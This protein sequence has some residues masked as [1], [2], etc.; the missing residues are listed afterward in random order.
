MKKNNVISVV[1]FFSL[2]F[3]TLMV[4]SPLSAEV[5]MDDYKK[6][7]QE[8]AQSLKLD[9]TL[10]GSEAEDMG[11]VTYTHFLVKDKSN[12]VIQC[13]VFRTKKVRDDVVGIATAHTEVAKEIY[14]DVPTTKTETH[15]IQGVK[16]IEADTPAY[17]Y[18]TVMYNA[19]IPRVRS[20]R[21]DLPPLAYCSVT[22]H[23]GPNSEPYMVVLLEHLQNA[24]LLSGEVV[25]GVEE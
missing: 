1:L 13:T 24:G 8:T 22:T 12:I 5:K 15:T 21:V 6:V 16:V 10:D 19:E 17:R 2:L 23:G 14:N 9:G 11:D 20:M 25:E 4:C 7:I 18:E 3:L